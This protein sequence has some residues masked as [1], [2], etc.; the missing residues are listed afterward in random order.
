MDLLARLIAA[1]EAY[2]RPGAGRR[3]PSSNQPSS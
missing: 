3:K 2:A 1:N